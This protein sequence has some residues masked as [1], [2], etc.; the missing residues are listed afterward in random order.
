[1]IKENLKD[2]TAKYR[3]IIKPHENDKTD[4]SVYG[5]EIGN[6]YNVSRLFNICDVVVSDVSSV[7]LEFMSL[8]RPVVVC[9]SEFIKQ[10]KDKFPNAHEYYFQN[11]A[12]FIVKESSQLLEAVDRAMG[13]RV[14]IRRFI[15]SRKLMSH[16]GSA[17][18]TVMAQL[19]KIESD[20]ANH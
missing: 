16:R 18:K 1:M 17:T 8:N 5:A 15:N 10:R 14:N 12:S 7:F 4:W 11:G 3:V 20:L 13:D 6:E 19:K 2:I 9:E